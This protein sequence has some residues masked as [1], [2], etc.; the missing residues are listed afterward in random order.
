MEN[1]TN[2]SFSISNG[3]LVSSMKWTG[4]NPPTDDQK[5]EI[6]KIMESKGNEWFDEFI[7]NMTRSMCSCVYSKFE[8]TGIVKNNFVCKKCLRNKGT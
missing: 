4:E 2:I 3:G 8:K 5:R 7:R 1:L 6:S